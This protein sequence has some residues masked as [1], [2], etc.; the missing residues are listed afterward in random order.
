M[1]LMPSNTV[2][3]SSRLTKSRE[4][5]KDN[6]LFQQLK[7]SRCCVTD[8]HVKDSHDYKTDRHVNTHMVV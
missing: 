8:R 4:G 1:Q 3:Y 7:A 5:D 6:H 2:T